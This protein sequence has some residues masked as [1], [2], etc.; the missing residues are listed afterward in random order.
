MIHS[1]LGASSAYRWFE[2]PGSVALCSKVKNYSSAAADEGTDAHELGEKC[3]K[4]NKNAK[5]YIGRTMEKGHV[6]DDEMADAVQVYL[7]TVREDYNPKAGDK[8]LVEHKFHLE[9]VHEAMFGTNDAC[10]YKAKDAKLIVY[11]YKHGKG[12][13]VEVKNNKQLKYYGLGALMENS[14]PIDVIELVIVQP[15]CPHTDG[16]VRRDEIDLIDLLD[17]S[18]DL[19]NAALATEEPDALL[20]P[21]SHCDWCSAA[22]ICPKMKEL[23]LEQA[24]KDFSN[25]EEEAYDPEELAETLKWLDTLESWCKSVRA[26]AYNEASVRGVDIPHF[27]LVRK[28]S[29]RKFSDDGPVFITKVCTEL[30]FLD[31]DEISSRKINGI[32]AIEK[33][34]KAQYK[35]KAKTEERNAALKVLDGFTTKPEGGLAL[36]PEDDKREAISA[37]PEADFS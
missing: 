19:Y 21:G 10:V 29:N 24:Q 12:K 3:L 8:L 4:G 17:F 28:R 2:C 32:G 35:G 33:I 1:K 23:A 36:V 26:F 16:P 6:V 9:K 20:A 13:P 37:G 27:K 25:D 31:I 14:W 18:T 30:P 22:A 11:D 5:Q 15:R 7:D 34:I